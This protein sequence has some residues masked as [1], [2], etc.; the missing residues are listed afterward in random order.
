MKI[1][2]L[3]T[4]TTGL[5]FEQSAIIQIG[6]ILDDFDLKSSV[7]MNIKIRPHKGAVIEDGALKV[8][9][10]TREE[11]GSPDRVEPSAAYKEL[12]GVC[13]FPH[14]VQP[15]DRVFLCGY[16][17]LGFDIPMLY[18]LAHRSGDQYP[19][20]KFHWPGVDIAPLA[21]FYLGMKRME[22]PNFKLMTV[23]KALGI[24]V[25]EE[26]AHDALYDIEITRKMYYKLAK[27]MNGGVHIW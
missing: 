26:E 15:K 21:S 4:E 16:N 13:G 3:D 18:K 19:H 12:M 8:N 14:R 11:L 25:D 24:P 7:K 17:I 9:G 20:G 23:A 10:T 27:L 5:D 2:F 1:L 6:A 22:L